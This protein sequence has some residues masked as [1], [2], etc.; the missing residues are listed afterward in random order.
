MYVTTI[1]LILLS[2]L[3]IT[4]SS[5]KLLYR[6]RKEGTKHD[7]HVI[8]KSGEFGTIDEGDALFWKRLLVGSSFSMSMDLGSCVPSDVDE[9]VIHDDQDI[10]TVA[11]QDGPGFAAQCGMD[12]YT[13]K[14]NGIDPNAPDSE[15]TLRFAFRKV[16]SNSFFIRSRVCASACINGDRFGYARIGVMVR[17]SL[18]PVAANA[19]AQHIPDFS[20]GWSYRTETG[21]P[22]RI[23]DDGSPDEKCQWLTVEREEDQFTMS[24]ASVI[25]YDDDRRCDA[26]S[27]TYDYITRKVMIDMPEEVLVGLA[28]SGRKEYLPDF[29]NCEFTEA[30]FNDIECRGC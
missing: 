14:D 30:D 7:Q 21:G 18:D 16:S 3:V 26:E 25:D 24:I 10:G 19:F 22:T 9:F 29:D 2:T 28:V 15:D 13:V 17:E 1:A 6:L 23:L 8:S 20:G 5:E 12:C 4:V 11:S 27:E